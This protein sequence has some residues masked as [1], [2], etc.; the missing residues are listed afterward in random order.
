MSAIFA[1][2]MIKPLLQ[3]NTEAYRMAYSAE[4]DGYDR[5]WHNATAKTRRDLDHMVRGADKAKLDMEAA[6][7]TF[8]SD[9]RLLPRPNMVERKA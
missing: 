5:T 8:V 9:P 3:S 1:E 6:Q 4:C 7:L 2:P